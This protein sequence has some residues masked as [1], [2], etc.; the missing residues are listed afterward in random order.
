M[1]NSEC[2]RVGEERKKKEGERRDGNWRCR[3]LYHVD[4]GGDTKEPG[5][6]PRMDR[7]ARR[8]T[9]T[10]EIGSRT[11]GREVTGVEERRAGVS[12]G[13]AGDGG[14]SARTQSS[15]RDDRRWSRNSIEQGWDVE[16]QSG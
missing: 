6:T 16:T 5:A 15:E 2:V 10:G 7:G 14:L 1:C 12:V 9:G 4:E 13:S 8:Q 3:A 11:M